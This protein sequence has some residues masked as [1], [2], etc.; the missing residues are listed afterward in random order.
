MKKPLKMKSIKRY[1]FQDPATKERFVRE[2]YKIEPQNI[3]NLS[4]D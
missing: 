1:T 2:V 3:K 4:H